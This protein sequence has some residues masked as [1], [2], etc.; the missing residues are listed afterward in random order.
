MTRF[1]GEVKS[2]PCLC[3]PSERTCIDLQ[4]GYYVSVASNRIVPY[5]DGSRDNSLLLI[6]TGVAN[7]RL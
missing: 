7:E 2:L 6:D 1:V 4:C 5:S 3:G